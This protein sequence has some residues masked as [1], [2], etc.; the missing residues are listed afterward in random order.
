M[1]TLIE[2]LVVIAI[3]A[4]LAGML[5]PALK[6][7]R[8]KAKSVQCLSNLKQMMTVLQGYADDNKGMIP[9]YY[10]HDYPWIYVLGGRNSKKLPEWSKAASCPVLPFKNFVNSGGK[11]RPY[12]GT[13][14]TTY[15]MFI[16][17]SGNWMR[18]DT[19]KMIG[20]GY[21]TKIYYTIPASKRP[22]LGDS[23]QT[24]GISYGVLNQS[25]V[26]NAEN[27]NSGYNQLHVRHDGRYNLGYWDGHAGPKTPSELFQDRAA[28]YYYTAAGALVFL[29]NNY[30]E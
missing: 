20:S 22:I 4:I 3:I 5:L 30:P 6:K 10:D 1:F 26:V 8:D 25:Y 2:L 17:G 16:A 27:T 9:K 24:E 21:G 23:L 14:E 7:A 19:G 28:K 18:Y 13:M 15:G 29:G 12:R 11:N